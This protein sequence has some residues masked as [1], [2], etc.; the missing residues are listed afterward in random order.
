MNEAEVLVFGQNGYVLRIGYGVR[1]ARRLADAGGRDREHEELTCGA[2][3]GVEVVVV[4][5]ENL[6]NF[7]SRDQP[8]VVCDRIS[9]VEM[10]YLQ[11][12]GS[13][14]DSGVSCDCQQ[15]A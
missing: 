7:I 6:I 14:D 5:P 4:V 1:R 2:A 8:G 13:G 12:A 3:D 11:P 10:E 15:L 9:A